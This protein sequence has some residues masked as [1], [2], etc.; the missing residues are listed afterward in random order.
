MKRNCLA[1]VVLLGTPLFAAASSTAGG[2]TRTVQG[3][4][5][6]SVEVAGGGHE[7]ALDSVRVRTRDGETVRLMLGPAGSCAGC[8]HD[9][10]R[11]R[12]RVMANTHNGTAQVRTMQV[13][14]SGERLAFRNQAG[15]LVLA[16]NRA[17]DGSRTASGNR[18]RGAGG[19]GRH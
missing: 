15:E 1:A 12:A 3:T 6:G 18:F 11:I 5:I 17:C 9:G 2:E 4:V 8:V 10:D 14:R 7:A 13:R 16:R 19:G